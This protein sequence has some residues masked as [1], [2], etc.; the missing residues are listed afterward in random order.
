MTKI[1]VSA[2]YKIYD[3]DYADIVWERLAMLAST[4]GPYQLHLV[5]SASDAEKAKGVPNVVPHF[6]EKGDF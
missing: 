6:C 3:T 1:F 4:L 5:C 2:I